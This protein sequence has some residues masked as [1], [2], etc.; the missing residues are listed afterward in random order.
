MTSK[1]GFHWTPEVGLQP[2]LPS[3]AVINPPERITSTS[4]DVS[5]VIVIGSGYAGLV[6]ARDLTTQGLDVMLLEGRDRIGGRTWHSTVDGFNYDMGGTW[7]HWEMPHIYREMSLYEMQDDWMVTQNE[8]GKEDYMTINADGTKT[9]VTH[10]EDLKLF[11]DTWPKFCDI[12]G[13]QLRTT[14]PYPLGSQR[15]GEHEKWDKISCEER[16]QQ[17]RPDLT[18]KEVTVLEAVLLQMGGGPLSN[19][20][21]LDAMRWYTLGLWTETGL[22]DIA[23]RTRLR[24]GQ[25]SLARNIFQHAL[26]TGRLSYAFNNPVESISESDGVVTVTTR[27]KKTFKALQVICTIPL[28]V[29]HD[30]TFS[31]PLDSLKTEA[32][33][34]GQTNRCNK[35]HADLDS[36]DYLSWSSLASP[37]KGFVSSFADN[38]TPADRTHLVCFGPTPASPLGI[39][40]GDGI[41]GI[42]DAVKHL[43][44]DN[45]PEITRLV[46]HDWDKDEF[47]QGAW[48]F[49]PPNFAT[50]FLQAL[51]RRHGNVHFAN[52]DWSYG[53]RGWIDGAAEQ[54]MSS[55]RAVLKELNPDIPAHL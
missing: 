35:V 20:S 39:N 7:I 21:L 11:V 44:P 30:I 36:P 50:R 40:L 6:A 8:G 42:L 24:G 5:D 25:S 31:P 13:T 34:I 49:Y 23:L 51:R 10:E 16:M 1:E 27:S 55:A 53:W 32:F 47:S 4:K 22:N 43:L 19:M 38:L 54:G 46:Y 9:N 41:E 2:G 33:S 26:R 28:N 18:A 37:G 48:C 29:L 3:I 15:L 45:A 17:L 52:A 14:I 12:D